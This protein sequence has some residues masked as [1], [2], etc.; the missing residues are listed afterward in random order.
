MLRH[1]VHVRTNISEERST[2]II[3]VTRICELGTT[4]ALTSNK[5]TLQRITLFLVHQFL[6]PDDGGAMFLQNIGSYNRH[7]A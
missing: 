5:H 4:D 2:S 6:H 3:R 7:M 1:V